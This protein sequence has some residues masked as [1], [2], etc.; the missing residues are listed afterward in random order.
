MEMEVIDHVRMY[1]VVYSTW[2]ELDAVVAGESGVLGSSPL[3]SFL[4]TLKS[5]SGLE[6]RSFITGIMPLALADS[7]GYNVAKDITHNPIFGSLVGFRKHD[8]Q[9]ALELVPQLNNEQRAGAVKLMQRRGHTHIKT[10]ADIINMFLQTKSQQQL[11]IK[12]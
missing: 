1:G 3:R 2:T 12:A 10:L 8:L 6:V 7:S 11:A 9:R 5:L 4:E